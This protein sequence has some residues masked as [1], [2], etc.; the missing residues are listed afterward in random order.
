MKTIPLRQLIAIIDGKKVSGSDHYS[1]RSVNFG[2]PSRLQPHQVYFYTKKMSW[3]KQLEAIR[4]VKPIAVVLPKQLSTQGIPQK[5]TVIQVSDAYQAFW[6]L[7]LWNYKQFPVKTIG[8][9]GSSGKSTT[10]EMVT[11]I[12]KQRYP[13]IKTENNLN[14]FSYL[15]HY[16]TKLEPKHKLLVLEMGMNSL[17]NIKRQCQ[18]V[19]PHWGVVTNIGEAHAG[20]LGGLDL[21]VKAKQEL[22][23][24]IRKGGTILINAD[25]PRSRKL[26]L[27]RTKGKVLYFGIHNSAFF[28]ASNIR[29]VSGGMR[30]NAH[31]G[32]Q[33]FP[34]FLPT[35]GKH[36]VYNA[37]AAIGLAWLVGTSIP[38]IQK[39]LRSFKPPKM[40]LQ[41]ISGKQGRIL[42][43][44]AWNANPT[45]MIA[46]LDVLKQIAPDRLKVA[47]LGDMLEL[48]NYTKAAHQLVGKHVAKLNLYQ[49]ITVGSY[50]KIIADTAI[51]H[52]MNP[53]RVY[54][55]AHRN[56][57]LKHLLQL[58]KNVVIYFK[59]SRKLRFEKLVKA[60]RR[61]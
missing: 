31:I 3:T 2:R 13:L 26:S 28:R 38:E 59:A 4:Q 1:I 14:T 29:F 6:K 50:G 51:R 10:T 57:A 39:G 49:L 25:D 22:V 61:D 52:G 42:I 8:I 48:G 5:V 41:I 35:Y 18:I 46:G 23:D 53:R 11:S 32:S 33:E 47:V 54:H 45:S 40:R 55:F 43:N 15:P 20:S 7:A 21:V 19:Q 9:T 44:D 12:L 56:D 24:G 16:L 30:F 17:N 34:V 60:L 58:P 27:N 37:L 36:N